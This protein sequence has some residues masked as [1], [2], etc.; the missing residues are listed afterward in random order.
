MGGPAVLMRE[1]KKERAGIMR[2]RLVHTKA[3]HSQANLEII[4]E[5]AATAPAFKSCGRLSYRCEVW[6]QDGKSCWM[7][8]REALV[9]FSPWEPLKKAIE[10]AAGRND[11]GDYNEILSFTWLEI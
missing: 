5:A 9:Y 8:Q 10:Q 6:R 3:K 11:A 1:P 7:E 2:G 4:K